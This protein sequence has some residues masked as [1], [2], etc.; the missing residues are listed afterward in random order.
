[1]WPATFQ[2]GLR[3]H[4]CHPKP[5]LTVEPSRPVARLNM[6]DLLARSRERAS[7]SDIVAHPGGE[8][9]SQ[10]RTVDNRH[11]NMP[12]SARFASTADQCT[13]ERN[14]YMNVG[15]PGFGGLVK[16]FPEIHPLIHSHHTTMYPELFRKEPKISA[17]PYLSTFDLPHYY[18]L[19][20]HWEQNYNRTIFVRPPV[21][22]LGDGGIPEN[23]PFLG[24][25]L[26]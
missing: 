25:R 3:M 22:F 9:I 5:K 17:K 26:R 15:F 4:L 6:P 12:E 23:N 8:E 24:G 14:T 21:S 1:M 2:D 7:Q 18:S 20:K 11:L 13:S 10:K 19:R 16:D